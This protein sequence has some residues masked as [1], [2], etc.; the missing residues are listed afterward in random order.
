MSSL[1]G[2][3][4]GIT[5]GVGLSGGGTSGDVSLA[6]DVTE[7]SSVV[8]GALGDY[9]VIHDVNNNDTFFTLFSYRFNR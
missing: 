7:I 8:S 9:V 6:L 3:V 1:S 4:T 2:D 5:A